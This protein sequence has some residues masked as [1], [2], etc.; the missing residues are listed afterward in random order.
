V[1]VLVAAGATLGGL[2]ASGTIGT[3]SP[4]RALR[5]IVLPP[6]TPGPD[7]LEHGK[8]ALA[9]IGGTSL[10]DMVARAEAVFVGE[11]TA[12]GG[13]EMLD[14][15]SRMEVHRVRFV[16][17][18][19]FRGKRVDGIDVTDLVWEG[20]I[21][22]AEVARRYLVFAEH[23]QLGRKRIRRLV[24][25]A[26]RKASIASSATTPPGTKRTAEWTSRRSATASLPQ[27]S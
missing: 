12:I 17:E 13:P 8:Y 6:L 4:R 11:V 3:E 25:S 21:F 22:P 9:D 1:L 16:V 5:H 24:A 27:A 2:Y 26:I 20:A 10:D 14:P 15:G 18:D 19:V 23:R 7:R